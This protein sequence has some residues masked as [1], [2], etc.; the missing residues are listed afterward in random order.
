MGGVTSFYPDN[1][2]PLS[3]DV[4]SLLGEIE[5]GLP[6]AGAP[7]ADCRP[8]L[9]VIETATSVEVVVDI[10]GVQP[11]AVRVAIREGMLLIV[12]AKRAGP[13]EPHA[14]YHLAERSY[15]RFARA[16]RLTGAFD[17]RGARA[18]V[19]AGQLRVVLPVVEER[20]GRL[21]TIPVEGA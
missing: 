2:A 12:G 4:Q 6:G 15:G 16:V 18:R 14:K 5:A 3:E 1:T 9:D 21:L 13:F 17:G 11:A 10:P 20:R 19:H 8:P 7:D